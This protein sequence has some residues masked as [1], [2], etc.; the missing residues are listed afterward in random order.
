MRKISS[1]DAVS[2]A[3]FA[4]LGLL[5]GCGGDAA[6]GSKENEGGDGTAG[7]AKDAAEQ[8]PGPCQ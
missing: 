5:G 7:L 8:W 1:F 6:V 4:A 3:L 2:A